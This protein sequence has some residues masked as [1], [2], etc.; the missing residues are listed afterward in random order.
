MLVLLVLLEGRVHRKTRPEG[1]ADGDLLSAA[2]SPYTPPVQGDS[3]PSWAAA[4]IKSSASGAGR[5]SDVG[6]QSLGSIPI[7][8]SYSFEDFGVKNKSESGK[9]VHAAEERRRHG[10]T[11][12]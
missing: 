3:L 2:C 7:L 9:Y 12:K 1:W 4:G 10:Y 5:L 6:R 11:R 8:T